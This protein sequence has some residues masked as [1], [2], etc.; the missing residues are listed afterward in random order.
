MHASVVIGRGVV[1]TLYASGGSVSMRPGSVVGRGADDALDA[2]GGPMHAGV[3][4]GADDAIEA[5]GCFIQAG[6]VVG[7]GR[8]SVHAVIIVGGGADDNLDA[9]GSAGSVEDGD[10]I[11]RSPSSMEAGVDLCQSGSTAGMAAFNVSKNHKV[12]IIIIIQQKLLLNY[13]ICT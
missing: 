1:D 6:I 9:R 7:Q 12:H 2:R 5:R 4:G 8:G 13:W 11:G 3:G 10:N